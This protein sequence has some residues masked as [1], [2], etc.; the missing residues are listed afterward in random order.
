MWEFLVLLWNRSTVTN[1]NNISAAL[2]LTWMNL[3]WVSNYIHYKVW[4]EITD[5]FQN[6]NGSLGMDK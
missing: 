1:I 2:L 3:T 5:P 4:N 6:F